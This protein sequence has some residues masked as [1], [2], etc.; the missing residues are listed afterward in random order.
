MSDNWPKDTM[1]EG[2]P[3]VPE[4]S[5]HLGDGSSPSEG[6]GWGTSFVPAPEDNIF[7]PHGPGPK[8]VI[9]RQPYTP[10]TGVGI[11]PLP[12]IASDAE[13]TAELLK[14]T[15]PGEQP[16]PGA[17]DALSSDGD[18]KAGASRS[19]WKFWKKAS[20]T[21]PHTSDDAQAEPLPVGVVMSGRFP[22]PPPTINTNPSRSRAGTA[23]QREKERQEYAPLFFRSTEKKTRAT[24]QRNKPAGITL[25]IVLL[26]LSAIPTLT[27][28]GML[29]Y[30]DSI[31]DVLV[32]SYNAALLVSY[33]PLAK[34][35]FFGVGALYLLSAILL[36]C[37]VARFPA[38][39]VLALLSMAQ[40]LGIYRAMSANLLDDVTRAAARLPL[41]DV[42]YPA[43]M[44][45]LVINLFGLI[46]HFYALVRI[47]HP[48]VGNWL[49][50][51]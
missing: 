9:V 29:T 36:G 26:I 7:I 17:V 22:A 34:W 41:S 15:E 27:V 38:I 25:A 48:S 4:N 23:I 16:T 51:D 28:A 45:T 14:G 18:E 8:P 13:G 44:I 2:N 32:N 30:L 50:D 11:P 49:K 46:L 21:E 33:L 19:K 37:R 31:S 3:F 10:R 43:Y 47:C 12:P 24:F 35:V 42:V 40:C 6:H 39:I 5:P 1:D 20:T